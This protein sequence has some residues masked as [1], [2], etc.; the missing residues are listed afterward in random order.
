MRGEHFLTETATVTMRTPSGTRDGYGNDLLTVTTRTV[1]CWHAQTGHDEV[2]PIAGETCEAFFPPGDPLR[3]TDAVTIAGR[4]FEVI[5]TPSSNR[6]PRTGEL[7]LVV[8]TLRR[9]DG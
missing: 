5:G 2:G 8:A 1:A 4:T 7:T 6:N 3:A 9:T